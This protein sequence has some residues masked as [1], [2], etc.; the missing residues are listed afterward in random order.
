MPR[1][2]QLLDPI[3]AATDG[4]GWT[5]EEWVRFRYG[6]WIGCLSYLCNHIHEILEVQPTVG[7]E[8]IV[9]QYI[10][11]PWP[12]IGL[13]DDE[14]SASEEMLCQLSLELFDQMD[15]Y[16]QNI[17]LERLRAL[18]KDETLTWQ[19]VLNQRN[20]RMKSNRANSESA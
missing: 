17:G 3:D 6:E 2:Y 14:D 10:G 15:A 8:V 12:C 7:A 16:V 11:G 9:G 19:D 1:G 20:E 13:Y 18:A 4:S 5:Q